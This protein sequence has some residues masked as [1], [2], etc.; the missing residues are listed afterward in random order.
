MFYQT[1]FISDNSNSD[2]RKSY[3]THMYEFTLK[4]NVLFYRNILLRN[5]IFNLLLKMRI[6]AFLQIWHNYV[7]ILV[8]KYNIPKI[9]RSY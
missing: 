5:L 6:V 2:I 8:L 7:I 3:Y 9:K 1:L 4:T